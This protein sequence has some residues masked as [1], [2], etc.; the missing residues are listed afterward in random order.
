MHNNFRPTGNM[1]RLMDGRT[2][3]RNQK[4]LWEDVNSGVLLTEQQ[5]G[6]IATSAS[7]SADASGG[8]SRKITTP[9]GPST[10]LSTPFDD[11][12]E[13]PSSIVTGTNRTIVTTDGSVT[14]TVNFEAG[15][16]YSGSTI[17]AYKNDTTQVMNFRTPNGTASPSPRT[18]TETFANGDQLKFE[19]SKGANTNPTDYDVTIQKTAPGSTEVLDTFNVSYT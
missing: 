11:I 10:S 7:F 8:G 5:L 19:V 9:A 1:F 17:I 6:L 14:L 18:L 16:L 4:N 15:G 2:F 13:V 3:K 12:V